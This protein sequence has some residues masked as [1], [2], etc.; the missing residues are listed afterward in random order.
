MYLY[1]SSITKTWYIASDDFW[2]YS[3]HW[4]SFYTV[5]NWIVKTNMLG[6]GD[7]SSGLMMS[8]YFQNPSSSTWNVNANELEWVDLRTRSITMMSL[9]TPL[10]FF[11][12][13][14]HR[15][16]PQNISLNNTENDRHN[17]ELSKDERP[18]ALRNKLEVKK[19]GLLQLICI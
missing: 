5:I 16:K 11:F 10:H 14:I 15:I 1:T 19:A 3:T 8:E 7:L 12:C 2:W 6:F 18:S 13:G 17:W 4:Y 9:I